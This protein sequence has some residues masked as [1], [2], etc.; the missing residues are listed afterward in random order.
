MTNDPIM[1]GRMCVCACVRG[2]YRCTP[3]T[4]VRCEA[5]ALSLYPEDRARMAGIS[6]LRSHPGRQCKLC[7]AL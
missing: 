3:Y 4:Y 1:C 5:K 2:P 6:D 7:A